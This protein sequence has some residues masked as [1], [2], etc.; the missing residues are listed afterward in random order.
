[1][2]SVEDIFR[3]PV[4]VQE[5]VRHQ[6]NNQGRCKT[7]NKVEQVEQ[8]CRS[9]FLRDQVASLTPQVAQLLTSRATNLP[10]RNHLYSLAIS[11]SV[12][13]LLLDNGLFTCELLILL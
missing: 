11:R 5:S 8:L 3:I 1:M 13:E 7:R 2:T 6:S 12:A 9:T 4:E 10:D